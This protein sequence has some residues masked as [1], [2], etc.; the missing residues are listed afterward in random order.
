MQK[1]EREVL[2][3]K[4]KKKPKKTITASLLHA[5]SFLVMWVYVVR[6]YLIVLL[7]AFIN[8]H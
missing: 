7:Y 2:V 8:G 5:E 3:T 6:K 1:Q 4:K